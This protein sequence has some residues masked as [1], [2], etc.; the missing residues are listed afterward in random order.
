MAVTSHGDV[1]ENGSESIPIKVAICKCK[2]LYFVVI[3]ILGAIYLLHQLF[4]RDY[5]H[6]LPY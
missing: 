2:N 5:L 3:N 1:D 6:E 4:L